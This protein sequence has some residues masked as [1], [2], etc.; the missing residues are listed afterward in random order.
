MEERLAEAHAG[1]IG[2]EERRE[3]KE[4]GVGPLNPHTGGERSVSGKE[5]F[6]HV[7]AE[8]GRKKRKKKRLWTTTRERKGG[9]GRTRAETECLT[10][11][12]SVGGRKKKKKKAEFF[13]CA[14]RE[15]KKEFSGE[16]EQLA[17]LLLFG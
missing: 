12:P 1:V 5:P 14:E 3:K 4:G 16:K 2:H 9:N 15:K 11:H 8:R 17:S 6:S 10:P 13:S 7:N